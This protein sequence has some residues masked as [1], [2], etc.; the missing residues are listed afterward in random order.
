MS[1]HIVY[2]FDQVFEDVPLV[3]TDTGKTIGKAK[4]WCED[5]AMRASVVI[6]DPT[7]KPP[8]I[9]INP[10]DCYSIPQGPNS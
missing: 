3:D 9:L 7:Y 4:V 8:G 6:E 1:E 10:I 2:A 5:G